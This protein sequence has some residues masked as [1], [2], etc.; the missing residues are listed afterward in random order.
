MHDAEQADAWHAVAIQVLSR[1]VGFESALHAL[2][3]LAVQAWRR[4]LCPD[5]GG[6]GVRRGGRR[7]GGTGVLGLGDGLAEVQS[8]AE[9]CYGRAVL[10]VSDL[11]LIPEVL[12][13][14]GDEGCQVLGGGVCISKIGNA[15][16]AGLLQGC[17]QG[18]RDLHVCEKQG[19]AFRGINVPSGVHSARSQG[20]VAAA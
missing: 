13:L 15:E 4:M 3:C 1:I 8:S 14:P 20:S 18:L 11:H 16:K 7:R 17:L 2:D 12:A 10:W 19:E 6:N 5:I 9:A